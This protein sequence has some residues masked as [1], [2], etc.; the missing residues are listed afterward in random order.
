MFETGELNL[1]RTT[2]CSGKEI[3]RPVIL[4]HATQALAFSRYYLGQLLVFWR[5]W[6]VETAKQADSQRLHKVEL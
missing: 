1:P 6:T 3:S 2:R 4:L 5:R